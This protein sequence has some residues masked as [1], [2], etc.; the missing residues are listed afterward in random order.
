MIPP[1]H[2]HPLLL[3]FLRNR[4]CSTASSQKPTVAG[5][6][7]FGSGMHQIYPLDHRVDFPF[8]HLPSTPSHSLLKPDG[9]DEE[10][11]EKSP[12]T[13]P[14]QPRVSQSHHDVNVHLCLLCVF[15]TAIRQ[16]RFLLAPF[17][18]IVSRR[19]LT[20]CFPHDAVA[21]FPICYE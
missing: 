4:Y 5:V 6:G 9:I 10:G 2:L 8:K 1:L 18:A 21:C 13:C 14:W 17:S 19:S 3:P 20:S 16:H 12:R 7:H 11:L 15:P